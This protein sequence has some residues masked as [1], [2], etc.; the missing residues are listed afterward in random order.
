MLRLARAGCS[1]PEIYSITGH[2]PKSAE[3]ILAKHC[4]SRDSALAISAV[5]KLEKHKARTQT[6]NGSDDQAE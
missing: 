3:A 6:V 4:L 2:D 5:E 1:I